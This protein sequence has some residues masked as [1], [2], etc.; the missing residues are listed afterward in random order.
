MLLKSTGESSKW[1]KISRQV[2]SN[3]RVTANLFNGKNIRNGHTQLRWPLM[4]HNG[5]DIQG[6]IKDPLLLMPNRRIGKQKYAYDESN[7]NLHG[8]TYYW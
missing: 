4:E 1:T 3:N 2:N 5:W 6:R 8:I 7:S